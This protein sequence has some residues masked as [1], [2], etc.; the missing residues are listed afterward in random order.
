[1]MLS[2][3]STVFSADS[4][5]GTKLFSVHVS[6]CGEKRLSGDDGVDV[7]QEPVH[8]E[9][10]PGAAPLIEALSEFLSSLGPGGTDLRQSKVALREFRAATVDPV[11]DIYDHINSLILARNF[12]GVEADFLY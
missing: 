11:E 2:W 5:P 3:V 9:V 10:E 6:E 7:S 12:F 1:M 4:S 8:L